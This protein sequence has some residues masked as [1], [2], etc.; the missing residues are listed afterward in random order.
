LEFLGT[1]ESPVYDPY[2]K[3]GYRR[4]GDVIR[5]KANWYRKAGIKGVYDPR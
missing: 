1:P 3:K 5:G 2:G 4:G